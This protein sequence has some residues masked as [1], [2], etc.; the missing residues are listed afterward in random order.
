MRTKLLL[1][2]LFLVGTSLG[3]PPEMEGH[4][5]PQNMDAIR[6]WKLTEVLEL[7]EEQ[8]VTFLPLVQI[9]ERQLRE[10]Q[11]EI[12]ALSKE[13]YAVMEKGDVT[14]KQVDKFIKSYADKQSEIYKI[15]ND[16]VK[17]LPKHLTPKQQLIY[18]GFETR[19]RS[20]LREYMKNDRRGI[21]KRT[22]Y[23]TKRQ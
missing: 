20:E 21:Q 23:E 12:K 16:F 11:G 5:N 14:Q 4:M 3:Q 22:K 6:I 2:T 1:L 10:I 9:H 15:K 18:L 8:V 13:A 17:A 19:F 7:T